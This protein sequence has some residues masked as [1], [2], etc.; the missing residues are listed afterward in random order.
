MNDLA[1]SVAVLT[2][3]SRG[4]GVELARALASRGMRL[5]L[6]ART[7]EALEPVLR[8]VAALGAAAIAVPG[9][10]TEAAVQEELVAE[11]TRAF[12]AIDLLVNNAGVVAPSAYEH[13]PDDE[14]ERQ[15][16]LN[17]AAPMR[18]TRRVLAPMLERDRGHIV[19]IASLGGLVGVGWGEAYAA[20]KHG[21][22]GFTRSL[23]LS[24]RASGSRVSA[25]V[26]CPGFIEDVGMYADSVPRHGRR[27]PLALGTSSA[28]DVARA[29]LEAIDRDL[30]EVIVCP[31][32]M[33][34][35]LALGAIRPTAAE[36]LLEKLGAHLVFE[37]DARSA[38][39]ARRPTSSV[40]P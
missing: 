7:G 22:V 12:G 34:L 36:W 19:N 10:V 28:K 40:R 21:L 14:L 38:G 11:A 1:G 33:R 18:L 32:P 13:M 20:S 37:A 6:N 15:L 25:S 5:V 23:R 30:P 2:G 24:A 39:R 26:I 4:L 3:A 35:V 29:T 9:D 31:R 8:D 27:A 17:L 16:G